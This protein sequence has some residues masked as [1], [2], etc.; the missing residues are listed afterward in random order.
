MTTWALLAPGP[1]ATRQQAQQV[2]TAGIRLGVISSAFPLARWAD[3]IAATDSAWWRSYPDA[4]H[5]PG[6]KFA[7]HAVPG[8]EKIR[9]PGWVACNSGVLGL[10]CAKRLG[11]TRILLL[12][13]DMHGTHYFGEYT[14]GLSNTLPA[15]RRMHLSQYT[16]WQKRNREIEVINCTAGSALQCFPFEVLDDVLDRAA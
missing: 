1:S 5:L 9:V 12:G 16:T 13:F 7:I 10:E 14:N 4:K 3:F 6:R 8:V 11:A 2:R 15:R